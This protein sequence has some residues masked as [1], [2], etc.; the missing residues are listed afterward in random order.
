MEQSELLRRRE[1]ESEL[2][3][4]DALPSMLGAPKRLV[5]RWLAEG[6]IPVARTTT[7]RRHGQIVEDLDFHPEQITALLP[8]VAVWKGLE[9]QPERKNRVGNSAIAR[10]AGL[11]R[12]AAHFAEARALDRRITGRDRPDQLRQVALRARTPVQSRKRRRARPRCVCSRSN[13]RTRCSP[14]ACRPA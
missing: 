13:S 8:Q 3:G 10:R 2:V 1:W 9:P 7:T 14:V 4:T 6:L 5:E 12:F 11:D